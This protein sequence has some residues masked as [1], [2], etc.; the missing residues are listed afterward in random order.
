MFIWL[1]K[2]YFFCFILS[3][4]HFNLER[5]QLRSLDFQ[6]LFKFCLLAQTLHLSL[7]MFLLHILNLLPIKKF[8]KNCKIFKK[9]TQII[10]TKKCFRYFMFCQKCWKLLSKNMFFCLCLIDISKP[11]SFK[12]V[13]YQLTNYFRNIQEVFLQICFCIKNIF[14]NSLG[15]EKAIL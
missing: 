6:F 12:N 8:D 9:Q 10:M 15:R 14:K 2:T 7:P 1:L 13:I 4:F 3:F 11:N 5:V